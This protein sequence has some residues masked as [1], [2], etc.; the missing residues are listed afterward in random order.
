V[1]RWLAVPEI[2][3]V[4]SN[5]G[6]SRIATILGPKIEQEWYAKQGFFG[7]LP[8]QL[9][10][11]QPP[12]DPSL[13]NWGLSTTMTVSFGNGIAVSPL[14]LVTGALPLVN[15]GIRYQ[16]TLLAVDPNGPQPAGVRVMSQSTS[17]IMRR[18]MTDVVYSGTGT[19]AA[20][21]V[22]GYVVGGKTGTAQVV[23]PNGRYLKHTN[24]ASFMAAFPMESPQYVIYVLVLQPKADATTHGFT[25]GGMIAAPTVARVIARIGPMLGVLPETGDQLAASETALMLPLD[26]TPPPGEVAL[27]PGRP[28]P[29][30]ANAFAYQLMGEKAPGGSGNAK[31]R[32]LRPDTELSAS[33]GT[34]QNRLMA[35]ILG[36]ANHMHMTMA[37]PAAFSPLPAGRRLAES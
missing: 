27:G 12:M 31:I 14:H 6:A 8:V 2:I 30:G 25:T 37:A 21:A 36:A 3:N 15:G 9:P 33:H 7:K 23:G 28:L 26:P 22:P 19:G 5:I 35:P 20:A 34:A 4:S 32:T 24:N 1:N 29:P 16:P 17:D 13:R 11:A 18:L 10:E